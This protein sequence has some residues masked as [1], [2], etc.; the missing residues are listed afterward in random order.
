MIG[1]G[2]GEFRIP[3]LLHAPRLPVK[4]AAGANTVIGLFVV[5][6]RVARRRGQQRFTADDLTVGAVMAAASIIG[7]I[8]GAQQAHRLSTRT[9]NGVICVY[10]V[11]VGVWM[12]AEGLAHADHSLMAPTGWFRWCSPLWSGSSSPLLAVRWALPVGRYCARLESSDSRRVSS[13]E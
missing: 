2:D 11:A 5:V 8:I 13:E 10:L 9:L 7:A 12:V 4:A 3:V 6:L 1:V